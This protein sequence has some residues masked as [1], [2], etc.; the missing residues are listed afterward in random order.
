VVDAVFDEVE[1]DGDNY[2]PKN[3]GKN[4]VNHLGSFL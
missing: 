4:G 3:A 1:E 2:H